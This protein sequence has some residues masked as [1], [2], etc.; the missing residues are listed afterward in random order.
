ML[1]SFTV[2]KTN[3][4]VTSSTFFSTVLAEADKTHREVLDSVCLIC[5]MLKYTKLIVSM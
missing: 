5:Q 1:R 3:G 4:E 2:L